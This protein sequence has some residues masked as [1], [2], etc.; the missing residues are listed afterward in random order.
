MRKPAA[1]MA[2]RTGETPQ[3]YM[4]ALPVVGAGQPICAAWGQVSQTA[5]WWPAAVAAQPYTTAQAAAPHQAL[6]A[7]QESLAGIASGM[8]AGG[9]WHREAPR[10]PRVTQPWG[11]PGPSGSV[12]SRDS[13]TPTRLMAV[14]VAV[15]FSAAAEA[16]RTAAAEPA[17]AMLTQQ[18]Q[19]SA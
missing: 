5:C 13:V 12:A 19:T 1:L 2:E 11:K 9:P 6:S 17:R 16:A 3:R 4:H 18:E 10:A 8:L 15:A 7:E 14:A